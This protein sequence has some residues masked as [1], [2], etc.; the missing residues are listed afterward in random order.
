MSQRFILYRSEGGKVIKMPF[1]CVGKFLIVKSGKDD[2]GIDRFKLMLK[3]SLGR[4]VDKRF[5]F[6]HEYA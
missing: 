4:Y 1:L 5:D 2:Q 6:M 3:S